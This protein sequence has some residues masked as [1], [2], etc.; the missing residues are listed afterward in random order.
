MPFLLESAAIF[1]AV[2]VFI[3]VVATKSIREYLQVLKSLG[4]VLFQNWITVVATAVVG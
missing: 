1:A 4:L 2:A 3:A